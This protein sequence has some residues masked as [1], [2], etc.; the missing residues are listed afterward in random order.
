MALVPLLLLSWLIATPARAAD[1]SAT[2]IGATPLN[3]LGTG[4]YAG[5]VG[6]LYPGGGNEPPPEHRAEGLAR[7]RAVEPL[8]VN[9]SPDPDGAFVLLSIGMSNTAEEFCSESGAEPCTPWSFMGQAAEHPEVRDDGLV[10]ANGARPGQPASE[11]DAPEDLNYDRVRDQVLAPKGVSEAQVRIV[12]VKQANPFPQ[13][14]LP[15]PGAD[16]FALEANLGGIARAVRAR[17]PNATLLLLSSRIYAGYADTTLNPEPFA[18]ESGF[19]V[20]WAIEAQIEQMAGGGVDPESGDLDYRSSAPWL[21]WGPYLWAD[22]TTARADG[23]AWLCADLE[24]D[25]THPAASGEQKVGALLLDFMLSSPFAAPWFR[26][27]PAAPALPLWASLALAGALLLALWI[28]MASHD[29]G[30]RARWLSPRSGDAR[31]RS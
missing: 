28:R 31:R 26:D 27:S 29:R 20:K 13:D 5:L 12:W 17:Y 8:D 7:A 10:L 16:A 6:G 1:C 30:R 3:E 21:G 9:G 4:T 18:Y 19:A 11:W 2:S 15:A 22:G 14:A 24:G 23:L 25:G